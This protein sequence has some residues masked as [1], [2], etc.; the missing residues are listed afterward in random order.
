MFTKN[1]GQVASQAEKDSQE[2]P[3]Q[4]ETQKQ[5]LGNQKG[6]MFSEQ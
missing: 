3:S 6:M 5:T 1:L 2:F 4:W